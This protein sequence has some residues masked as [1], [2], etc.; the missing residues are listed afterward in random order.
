MYSR[1]QQVVNLLATKEFVSQLLH[2]DRKQSM[3]LL[4]SCVFRKARPEE[5]NYSLVRS[6]II[7]TSHIRMH[8][9]NRMGFLNALCA[10]SSLF[11]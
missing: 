2:R 1:S 8:F 5:M 6:T 3:N 7:K 11:T 9:G 10:I 4:C